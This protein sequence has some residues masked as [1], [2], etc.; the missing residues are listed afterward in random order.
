MNIAKGK[1][2]PPGLAKK[3]GGKAH[4]FAGKKQG[5][6]QKPEEEEKEDKD[7]KKIDD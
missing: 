4:G 6:D 3:G 2:M 7:D 5:K 1:P